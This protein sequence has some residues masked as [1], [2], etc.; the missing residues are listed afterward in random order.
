MKKLTTVIHKGKK[1]L[2][3]GY[4]SGKGGH[5]AGRGQKGQKTRKKLGLMFEGVKVKKSFIKRLPFLRGKG[6][7]SAQ[8]KPFPIHLE[9][10]QELPSGTILNEEYLIKEGFVKK[11]DIS[12]KGVKVLGNYNLTKKLTVDLPV[13]K[14]AREKII[15]AG[16]NVTGGSVKNV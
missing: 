7:F 12:K 3:R 4:G 14:K 8:I 16:G 11:S 13:S 15:E 6:R 2:G 5:T 10:L 9:A 1:R